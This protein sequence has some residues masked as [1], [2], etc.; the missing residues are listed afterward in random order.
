MGEYVKG[1]TMKKLLILGSILVI[2]IGMMSGFANAAGHATPLPPGYTPPSTGSSSSSSSASRSYS[3]PTFEEYTT[4]LKSSDGST[5]GRF[6]GKNFNSVFVYAARNATLDNVSY[7]LSLEGELSSKPADDCWLD[8]TFPGIGAA[9]LPPG[10]ENALVFGA[11]NVTKNPKDWS[12]KSGSPKYTLTITGY[13]GTTVPGTD[14]FIVRRDSAGY[15]IQKA[16]VEATGGRLIVHFTGDTGIYT[17][18]QVVPPAPAATP[19][20]TPIPTATPTPVPENKGIGGFPVF[21]GIFAVG[22][23]VGS[24]TLFLFMRKGK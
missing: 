3:T 12:Y 7:E 18:M 15:Q 24:S 10:M 14:Y 1:E 19:T 6:E 17:L 13:N 11:V 9:G 4:L 16:T 21:T 5:I 22:A 2:F 20:P 23:I 8:I